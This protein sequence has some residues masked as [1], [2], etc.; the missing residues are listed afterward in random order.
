VSLESFECD[1]DEVADFTQTLEDSI[2]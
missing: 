2:Y 1:F